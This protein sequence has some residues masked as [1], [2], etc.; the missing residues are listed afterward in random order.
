M[1]GLPRIGVRLHGGIPPHRCIELAQAAEAGRFESVWF[2]E[3]PF[4]RGVL[5]AVSASIVKTNRTRIGVGV[6]NPYNRHPS[7]IAM[8]FAALDELA[9]GRVLLG[10]GSGIRAQIERMGFAYRPLAAMTE[11]IYIVRA[12]LHGEEVTYRGRVFSADHISLGFPALR[13]RMP[14]YMAAMG[15][16]SLD[17][18][19]RIADG[20]IVSNMCP[21]SYTARAVEIVGNS[22]AETGRPAL[23]AVQYVPCVIRPDQ[24]EAR[25]AL[26]SAIGSML[27]TFWPTNGDWPLLR[28]TI[29]HHSGIPKSEVITALNRLRLGEPAADVLDNRYVDT[30]GIA[31]TTSDFLNQ[32]QRYRAA[33][34]TELVLTFAGPQPEVDMA[35]LAAALPTH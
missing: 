24:E 11:A 1:A 28:D 5:P 3:N 12:M 32:V 33:G 18:C 27:T 9:S 8:E 35:C 20:L 14:I 21:P 34:V 17:L 25:N 31:G 16:R 7:L 15:D 2:A 4:H 23:E 6:V 13:P 26:K 30:F 10:I 22:A 29:I 19:G